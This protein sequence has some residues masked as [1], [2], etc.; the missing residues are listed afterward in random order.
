[1]R[2]LLFAVC[3]SLAGLLSGSAHAYDYNYVSDV[4]EV[5]F[6]SFSGGPGG[7]TITFTEYSV[8]TAHIFSPTLLTAGSTWTPGTIVSMNR[9]VDN[10]VPAQQLIYPNPYADP[11]F[12][13]GSVWN[14]NLALTFTI[15]SVDAAGL[16]TV[17]DISLQRQLNT[18]TGR[19]DLN[20]LFISNLGDSASGGYQGFSMY[21]GSSS[22]SGTWTLG[23]AAVPEPEAYAMLL[24][25]LGLMAVAARRRSTPRRK[26]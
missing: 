11:S 10:G 18:P 23:V 19:E 22:G 24:A 9:F 4:F 17:W 16:P 7:S 13:P 5:E 14:P 1:M 12:P 25:G 8:I 21:S 2:N 26:A 6:T 3:V 20:N 15:G